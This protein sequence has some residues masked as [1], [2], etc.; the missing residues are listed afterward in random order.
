MNQIKV[1]GGHIDQHIQEKRTDS[2]PENREER[3]FTKK[4]TRKMII[5]RKK[6]EGNGIS[7]LLVDVVVKRVYS[8]LD[9]QTMRL[10]FCSLISCLHPFVA[11]LSS[12]CTDDPSHGFFSSQSWRPWS[13]GCWVFDFGIFFVDLNCFLPFSSSSSFVIHFS[14]VFNTRIVRQKGWKKMRMKSMAITKSQLRSSDSDRKVEEERVSTE[15]EQRTR[16][17]SKNKRRK[18]TTIK[19][20]LEIKI[21]RWCLSDDMREG[22]P[23]LPL[24][25]CQ[26]GV[27]STW[28][29]L[30][31]THVIDCDFCP[32][33]G[34]AICY[35]K[36]KR[37]YP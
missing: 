6:R 22:K 30:P 23:S 12:S 34:L 13:L 37:R 20:R 2:R 33:C 19:N 18:E 1:R 3:L 31:N 14:S 25:L 17:D 26:N 24:N 9:S 35:C 15:K 11:L 29:S 28:F 8:T 21:R 16:D 10:Q 5:F 7:W 36:V 32:S 27:L 4:G